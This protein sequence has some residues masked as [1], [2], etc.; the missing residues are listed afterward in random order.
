MLL[1]LTYLYVLAHALT[2]LVSKQIYGRSWRLRRNKLCRMKNLIR[3]CRWCCT[4]VADSKVNKPCAAYA[5]SSHM[6]FQGPSE[7]IWCKGGGGGRTVWETLLHLLK[8]IGKLF[9]QDSAQ[10]KIK[11]FGILRRVVS[12]SGLTLTEFKIALMMKAVSTS[13]TSVN[14]QDITG[15]SIPEYFHTRRRKN[16]KT[17]SYDCSTT[18]FHLENE[19]SRM[20]Y[21][22]L[23]IIRANGGGGD[24]RII[25]KHG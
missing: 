24:A 4:P 25:T 12:W 19:Q 22:I 5:I 3:T 14:L 11:H 16:L 15:R 2:R 6:S 7:L 20:R 21:T 9:L 10:F 8:L 23:S 17:N 1:Y 13:E 18:L